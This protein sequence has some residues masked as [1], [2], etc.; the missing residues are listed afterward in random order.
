[1][2][3][4]S[5][6]R[7]PHV[8]LRQRAETALSKQH[9]ED[10]DLSDLSHEELRR[11]V[12]E[13][14]VHQIE[15]DMQN[16]EL[17][18]VQMKL[19]ESRDRFSELYDFA[20]VGYLTLDPAGHIL[21]INFT[22]SR[23]LGQARESLVGRGLS[24]FVSTDDQDSYYL[25]LKRLFSS[26]TRQGVNIQMRSNH[27]RSFHALL[28]GSTIKDLEGECTTSRVAISDI[29]ALK[30]ALQDLHESK[31]TLEAILNVTTESILLLDPQG[32][33]HSLNKAA[34]DL[35]DG[36][37][38][39]LLG[40]SLYDLL[41]PHVRTK[42]GERLAEVAANGKPVQFE[43]DNG[44]QYF[45]HNLYPV[46]GARG[47]V[48]RIAVFARNITAEKMALKSLRE[49]EE[50]F[51]AVFE[52]ATECIFVM[53]RSLRYTHV[54]PAVSMLF[55]IPV[56][57]I[58]GMSPQD[59]YGEEIGKQVSDISVRVLAGES[60]EHEQIRPVS[61][62][63]V[64]FHDIRV[65]L[66]DSDNRIV[67]IC[68]L[69]RCSTQSVTTIKMFG[70]HHQE[71]PSAAM[72]NCLKLARSAARSKGIVL[73]L[74]ESGSGKD[75]LAR[76]IHDH[77]PFGSG[78]FL[79]VNCAALPKELAESEL[80]GHERG[81]FTGATL[82]K[83]G[84]LELA[85]GGTILLNEIGE[86]DLALQAKLLA[87]LDTSSFLR[88]GGVTPV[89]VNAR[90]LAATHRD[91]KKEV[92][93]SRF[94]EPLFYRLTV[95]PLEVPPL[96]DR[97]EDLPMLVKEILSKIAFEMQLKEL[98]M[99]D[100]DHLRVLSQYSWPGNVREL[101]NVIER[102]L[103]LWHG[104]RLRLVMD[105]TAR[106]SQHSG[107]RIRYSE[108]KTLREAHQEV[109]KYLCREALR[110]TKGSKREAA[111]LLGIS[112]DAFYRYFKKL[113]LGSEKKT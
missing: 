98:P 71:W 47:T 106:V 80:F 40:K 2:E 22:G 41:E 86:L 12:H 27:G 36:H 49:S 55:G 62:I 66:R 4:D 13:L 67:G 72:Q 83:K 113:G 109:T 91:L 54:N 88:V 76:W 16:E 87:F 112:R 107:I 48:E 46:V 34:A 15:L 43:D 70:M 74:G 69:S 18:Y 61:G 56:S 60:V 73:L 63:P 79:S 51:R 104:D 52:G 11:L 37:P 77:S 42:A 21:H 97:L 110:E 50:R 94:L 29:T 45:Q 82:R 96:R 85:E 6:H 92:S 95:F 68:C 53:D 101:R 93:E 14:R 28:E 102:S 10:P 35:F 59:M 81:A 1:M 23:L 99:I 7:S 19:E 64:N 17:R 111:A 38:D 78:P 30:Q 89:R 75:Y 100:E 33:I 3:G 90:L 105:R 20:P 57:K 32:R 25:F 58:V 24:R 9:G 5:V 44:E 103:M 39:D 31:D 108:G 84:Q 65:P 26:G 8:D